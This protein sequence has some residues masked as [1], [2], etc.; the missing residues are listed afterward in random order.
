MV[1]KMSKVKSPTPTGHPCNRERRNTVPE[2]PLCRKV[3]FL[4]DFGDVKVLVFWPVKSVKSVKLGY[5]ANENEMAPKAAGRRLP[6]LN[7]TITAGSGFFTCRA[8]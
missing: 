5:G 8:V 4:S 1:V 7:R 3:W 2:C 6:G